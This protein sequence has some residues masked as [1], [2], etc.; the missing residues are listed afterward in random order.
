VRVALNA[1]ELPLAKRYGDPRAGLIDAGAA[2]SILSA[3][4]ERSDVPVFFTVITALALFVPHT[5][6]VKVICS[7]AMKVN[8]NA[9]IQA[10]TAMLT[11]TVT[12]IRMIA[13]TTGLSAFLLFNNFHIFLH[14]PSFGSSR[15]T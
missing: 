10:A 3:D 1:T 8:V 5:K 15:K 13:A 11:A 9:P 7:V 6:L 14:Y 4:I 2:P 12:A